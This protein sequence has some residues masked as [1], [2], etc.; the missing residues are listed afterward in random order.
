MKKIRLAVFAEGC[1]RLRRVKCRQHHRR[2]SSTKPS[3]RGTGKLLINEPALDELQ[4][5]RDR[6]GKLLI[7]RFAYRSTEHNRAVD[8]ATRSKHMDG[9]AFDIAM[10]NHEPVTFEA[11]SRAVGFL[12]FCFYTSN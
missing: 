3:C 4:A 2:T 11:A 8:G 9:A 6:L 12:G 10:S 7:V 1:T 5:L